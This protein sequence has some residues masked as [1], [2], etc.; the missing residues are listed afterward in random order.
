MCYDLGQFKTLLKI[1]TELQACD[2]ER[3][4]L[5]LKN[6]ELGHQVESLTLQVESLELDLD[7]AKKEADH[8]YEKWKAENK[9]RHEAENAPRFG[10]STG[11]I[12]AGVMTVVTGAVI[13][14]AAFR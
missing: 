1:E 9:L 11:W 12:V 7:L 8:F 2:K 6:K 5:T 14:Y 3:F 13:T 4:L 10:N